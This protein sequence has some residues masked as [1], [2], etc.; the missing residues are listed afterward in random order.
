MLLFVSAQRRLGA[1]KKIL[2]SHWS[3][4]KEAVTV[5]GDEAE[6]LLS[7]RE[8]DDGREAGEDLRSSDLVSVFMADDTTAV[9][10]A[11]RQKFEDSRIENSW[12]V[13]FVAVAVYLWT[14]KRCVACLLTKNSCSFS[15]IR[16][17]LKY[18]LAV[19][20]GSFLCP[21]LALRWG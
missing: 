20:C 9:M 18:F 15:H 8:D 10:I 3:G 7:R 4:L 19:K 16:T 17:C 11:L 13:M 1:N 12:D 5:A 21:T 2:P 14:G 6:A